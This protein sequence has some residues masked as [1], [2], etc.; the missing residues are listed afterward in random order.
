MNNAFIKISN[1]N[2]ELTLEDHTFLDLGM[3]LFLTNPEDL[4]LCLQ[5]SDLLPVQLLLILSPLLEV[6]VLEVYLFVTHHPLAVVTR[7]LLFLLSV[8]SLHLPLGC[9]HSL[10]VLLLDLLG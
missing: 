8:A 9:T 4:T 7:Q 2:E 3:Q 1:A 6:S 10:L 5:A